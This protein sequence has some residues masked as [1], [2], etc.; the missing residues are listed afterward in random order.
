MISF[1][2]IDPTPQNYQK[3]LKKCSK[4][5]LLQSYPYAY[6]IRQTQQLQARL[7]IIKKNDKD[8]GFF[9]IHEAKTFFGMLHVL[10]IDRG[11]CWF[12]GQDTPENM[13]GFA[14]ALNKYAPK[15]IGRMRRFM[16]ETA[17]T[18]D[19]PHWVYRS[20]AAHYQTLWLDI[21]T[22]L[23]TIRK[24]FKR[25]WRN[26]LN[27]AEKK[28]LS[29]DSEITEDTL[30]WFLKGYL[31]DRMEK[32]YAGAGLRFSAHL[33]SKSHEQNDLVL[34]KAVQQKKT[35]AAVALI[36]HGQCA[37]YQIGWTTT[38]GRAVSAHHFLLWE[39]I[40]LLKDSGITYIDLGGI[41][42]ISA[43]GVTE[44]KRNMGAIETTLIGQFG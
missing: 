4:S 25:K 26:H 13:R 28:N 17:T 5:T 34:L 33:F 38:A 3:L 15:R 29:I 10:T 6:A 32:H 42:P 23:E 16:P 37:T 30:A 39:A 8:I 11:P 40:K 18:I 44:F 14:A 19:M 1:S 9:N 22:S 27:A 43:T 12:K 36:K 31:Q 20:K 21:S 7:A 35:I 41:N 2:F 24:G